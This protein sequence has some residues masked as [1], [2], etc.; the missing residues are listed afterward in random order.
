MS[1]L[2]LGAG[3]FLGGHVRRRFADGALP[4]TFVSR[5]PPASPL[6]TASWRAFDPVTATPTELVE[7]LRALRPTVVVNCV[8]A[9]SGSPEALHEVNVAALGRLVRA[10]DE[11]GGVRLVHLGSAAEYGPGEPGRPVGETG[12]CRPVGDYG[13]SKLAG[14]MLVE[15]AAGTGR[16]SALVLR[17][18]NPVGRGAPATTVGGA[19]ALAIRRAIDS[20]EPS[21]HLGPLDAVRDVIDARDVADAVAAATGYEG[22]ERIVNV[23]SGRPTPV[24][25]L[26]RELAEVAGYEGRIDESAAGAMRSSAVP[27]QQADVTRARRVLEFEAHRTLADAV[28]SLWEGLGRD[29]HLVGHGAVT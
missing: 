10:L 17:V 12:A 5:R 1:T 20:R 11:V 9:T 23:G 26:V 14:T 2:V 25:A 28:S 15:S 16:L 19:A 13:A 21:V 7:L 29:G 6:G 24:R 3:G 8:G 22:P 27:W 4:A 18:F